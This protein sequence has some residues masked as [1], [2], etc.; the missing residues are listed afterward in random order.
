LNPHSFRVGVDPDGPERTL[1]QATVNLF[2]DMDVQRANLQPDL[3]RA[4]AST[5]ATP[6]QSTVESPEDGATVTGDRVTVTGSATDRGG[7]VAGIEVSVDNGATWH[8]AT[9][10]DQWSYAW[11]VPEGSGT[12]TILSRASDDTVN[13]ETPGEGVT[14]TY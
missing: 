3:V 8:P 2:A 6:P 12:T 13:L 11:Q 7:V 14:V 10:T 5:D 9:G 1:Q 4:T